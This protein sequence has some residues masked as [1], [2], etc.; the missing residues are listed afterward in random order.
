MAGCFG[1]FLKIRLH[2]QPVDGKA[3]E[4]LISYLADML[5]VPKNAVNISHGHTSKRKTVEIRA[6]HL[7]VGMVRQILLASTA[8]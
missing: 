1:E 8:G 4:A 5:D 7:R 3:N 2:A 6:G